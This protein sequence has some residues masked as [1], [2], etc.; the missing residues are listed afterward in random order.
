MNLLTVSDG[1]PIAW[2]GTFETPL[3]SNC[4]SLS[5][6]NENDKQNARVIRTHSCPPHMFVGLWVLIGETLLFPSIFHLVIPI[7]HFVLC[8]WGLNR[9]RV[10]VDKG[11]DPEQLN[12]NEGAKNGTDSTDVKERSGRCMWTIANE[13]DEKGLVFWMSPVSITTFPFVWRSLK[14]LLLSQKRSGNMKIQ[15]V[16]D[17]TRLHSSQLWTDACK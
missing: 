16:R 12:N 17:E 1:L 5:W 11:T 10:H 8:A 4:L 13:R 15:P 9:G 3:L 14:S 6:E 7:L 2:A